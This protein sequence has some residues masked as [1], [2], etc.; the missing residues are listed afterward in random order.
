MESFEELGFDPALVEALA[1]EGAER[2]TPLQFAGIPVIRRG[3]NLVAHAGPGGG[4]L[5]TYGV[6][7]LDR[8]EPGEDRPRALV[9]VPTASAAHRLAQS[10]ARMAQATGHTVASLGAAWVMPERA[11]VLFATA[12]DLLAAARGGLKLEEVQALVIDAASTVERTTGLEDVETLLE[13]LPREVQRVVFALPMTAGVADFVDRHIKRAIHVPPQAVEPDDQGPRRGEVR[14]RIV[15]EPKEEAA[16][17]LAAEVLA[18]DARHIAFF[19]RSDDRAADVGDFLALHGYHSGYPGDPDVPVWLGVGELAALPVLEGAEGVTVVSF[20]VPD[21]PD[22]LDRRH[23]GGRGGIVM[24]LPREVA[25]MRDVAR[26][27]G[28]RV[29]PLP[30]APPKGLPGDLGATVDALKRAV[31]EEDLAPYL[32][33]IE[34][35]FHDHTA[36]EIAAAAMALLRKKEPAEAPRAAAAATAASSASRAPAAWVRLFI[37]VGERDQIRPGD[38]VGAITGEAGVDGSHVG[39]IEMK[40]SFSIVEVAE[41]VAEKVIRALNGTTIRGRSTRVDYDRV[42][43]GPARPTRTPGR[44]RPE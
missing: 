30:P 10:L 27:T 16:L 34:T 12:P 8:I 35:L 23:G 3:N 38:L 9:V 32:M 28:Y 24:V 29:V 2:P 1:A 17:Q 19:F 44:R 13:Y 14:F 7:L 31:E 37:S 41:A 36:H 11:D 4:T 26:R 40:D 42:R 39:K 21:G 43:R 22:S 5:I 25:H 20:D 18:D 6:G 15:D 33:V